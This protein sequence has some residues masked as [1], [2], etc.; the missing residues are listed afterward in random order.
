MWVTTPQEALEHILLAYR[1]AEDKRVRMP[2]AVAMDGA[3]LTHS[4]HM[5]QIP[6]KSA[7]KQFLPSYDLAE[8]RMHP[9]SP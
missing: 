6:S 2:C 4:Q 3:F 1:I 7:V 8:R 9:A 5:V